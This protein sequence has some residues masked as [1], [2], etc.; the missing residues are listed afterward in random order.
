MSVLQLKFHTASHTEYDQKNTYCEGCAYYV[1]HC[2]HIAFAHVEAR[3][4]PYLL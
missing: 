1:A 4:G 2:E 3:A